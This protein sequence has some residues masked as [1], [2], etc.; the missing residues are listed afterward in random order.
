M[1]FISWCYKAFSLLPFTKRKYIALKSFKMLIQFILLLV[2]NG[3]Q[4]MC[5]AEE[6][7][8][9]NTRNKNIVIIGGIHSGKSTLANI[10]LGRDKHYNGEQFGNGCF[11]GS[12]LTKNQEFSTT[13]EPCSNAGHLLGNS[14]LP[15][16]TVTDTPGIC[17]TL[18]DQHTC[19]ENIT[20][21]L[22]FAVKE[23]DL[24]IVTV[25]SKENIL[26]TETSKLLTTISKVFGNN[27]WSN[28]VVVATHWSYDE[29]SVRE[30][31][32]TLDIISEELSTPPA[33]FGNN[34][35]SNVIYGAARKSDLL[36]LT[37]HWWLYHYNSLLSKEF[38]L[39]LYVPG[40]FIDAFKNSN[41]KYEQSIFLLNVNKLLKLANTVQPFTCNYLHYTI[42]KINQ[43]TITVNKFN[44]TNEEQAEDIMTL[45]SFLENAIT[46]IKTLKSDVINITTLNS[47]HIEHL[48]SELLT[49]KTKSVC[50][51]INFCLSWNT[52]AIIAS[53]VL[54]ACIVF[55]V[56]A[57]MCFFAKCR[58]N[59]NIKSEDV[60]DDIQTIKSFESRLPNDMQS[61]PVSKDS[62]I[63]DMTESCSESNQKEVS[64]DLQHLKFLHDNNQNEEMF[65]LEINCIGEDKVSR[66]LETDEESIY[67]PPLPQYLQRTH[68][69][70][71]SEMEIYSEDVSLS[72]V[73]MGM[74]MTPIV[75]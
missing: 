13:K 64:V 16:I 74:L 68:D 35:W 22:Q 72:S 11:K 14:S 10:L 32:K 73:M 52:I 46:T 60:M 17:N 3:L 1:T 47:Q 61:A 26:T 31:K 36:K 38:S 53:V 21:Y 43:L 67:V 25:N 63:I 9:K 44:A 48:E 24:F 20:I 59:S 28:V 55:P 71:S 75:N 58:K 69:D 50:N 15:L 51:N 66:T 39:K 6:E 62:D 40:I 12:P 45:K 54:L 37:E 5:S 33:V 56:M 34:V 41:D 30:R 70:D 65:P 4:V 49:A 57:Y 2:S 7:L 8:Q 42:E 27:F 29:K 18:Q 23:V 19:T